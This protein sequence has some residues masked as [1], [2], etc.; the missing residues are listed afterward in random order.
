LKKS[1][2][3]YGQR[4]YT[5]EIS[6][7]GYAKPRPS[8]ELIPEDWEETF[9]RNT[10]YVGIAFQELKPALKKSRSPS[11]V[12]LGS[13]WSYKIDCNELLPY[14][15]AKH[16]LKTLT[17]HIALHNKWLKTNNYCVP[18]TDTPAY[19]RIQED[20]H[21]FGKNFPV[22]QLAEPKLIGASLVDHF[23]SYKTSGN[24][25][26]VHPTGK[27]QTLEEYLVQQM[28]GGAEK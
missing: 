13:Q 1:L 2:I 25:L 10:A 7:A 17:Q 26:K 3:S 27:I 16:S 14:I 4:L 9:K 5:Q 11:L 12:T 20:F 6:V 8:S 19:R 22:T 28:K 21:T 18:T 15:I 24:I 23:L